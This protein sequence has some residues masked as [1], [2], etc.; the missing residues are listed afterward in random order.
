MSYL[1]RIG[2]LLSAL[3]LFASCSNNEDYSA[4]FGGQVSNP[5]VPYIIFSKN[6]KVIDTIHLDKNNRFFV[7]FDSLTPG[8]YSFSHEPD[9]QYVYFDRNDSI[10]VSFNSNDF[11]RSVVFSGRGERKNN[12]MIEMYMLQETDRNN[13]YD[14]YSLDFKNFNK[15]IDSVYAQRKAFYDKSRG[16]IQWSTDFDFYAK[17]RTDFSYLARKEYYPYIHA[18]RTGQ[19]VL[20]SLPKDYYNFRKDI[21]FNDRRLTSF[22]PFLR[23]LNSML[24]NMAITRNFKRGGVKEDAL[25]NNIAKLNIADSIFKDKAIKDQILNSI[26]FNYL[27]EDQNILNNQ[28]FL[29]RYMQLSTDNSKDNE[30]RKISIATR[31]LKQGA[32][33][34][35]V[36]LVDVNNKPVDL[37]ED[38]DKQTVIF[39]WTSC[40]RAHLENVYRHVEKLKQ[41]H[42]NVNFIAINVDKDSEWKRVMALQPFTFGTQLRAVDYHE[43]KDKWAFTKINRTIILNPDG[44]IKNAFTDILDTKF[45][46]NL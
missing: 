41:A 12:F 24:S 9:Y 43:L 35:D 18:R 5:R 46:D 37:S 6:N 32:Q 14:L 34:P 29:E 25:K 28:K 2:T 11:D 27:L 22:S 1:Q 17:A 39:F 21:K 42:P 38:I 40:A 26:A 13:A 19:D 15:A 44:S 30:I 3:M 4:C 7:K 10:Q 23:Y 16:D 33:L 8:M 36:Q 31:N 20:S 45:G